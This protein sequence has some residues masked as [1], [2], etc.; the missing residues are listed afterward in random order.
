MSV[1]PAVRAH[2]VS[3]ADA[4]A[5]IQKMDFSQS[6]VLLAGFG[7]MG[8]AYFKALQRLGVRNLHVCV[9]SESSVASLRG[10]P[11]IRLTAGGY[12]K[13]TEDSVE[14]AA[15]IVAVPTDH[16]AGAV[17]RLLR[18]GCKR[19]L[20]EKPVSVFSDE[21]ENLRRLSEENGADVYCAFNR[22]A[23]PSFIEARARIF[24]AG[25]AT[26]SV[27]TF[28]ELSS[29][30]DL[31]QH[32][33]NEKRRWGIA[34]SLHVISMAHALIGVP[35]S[36]NFRRSGGLTWHPSGSVFVGS[37]VT[38][39]GTPFSYHADWGSAGRWSVEFYTQSVAVRLCPLEKLHMKATS[40]GEWSEVNV[41]VFA[42]DLKPGIAEE[43]A[44]LLHREVFDAIPLF[45][46]NWTAHLVRFAE[47][48]FGYG[49]DE[50]IQA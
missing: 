26:S 7:H 45:D 13:L 12:E 22:V 32:S 19:I 41:A 17:E 23:Y 39:T 2:A 15:A 40:L 16:L 47:D 18:L 20:C 10:K 38:E 25:G 6:K 3:S 48:I 49:S 24:E 11:G 5:L 1:T 34:N 37:G 50:V 31:S 27:Y 30:L 9:R 46:L 21:I 8:K 42:S 36:W 29:Q 44:A 33:E 14:G 28:T 43:T 35:Q 4:V